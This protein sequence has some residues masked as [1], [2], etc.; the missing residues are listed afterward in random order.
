[1]PAAPS[2]GIHCGVCRGKGLAGQRPTY[3]AQVRCRHPGEG[4]H[5]VCAH[6]GVWGSSSVWLSLRPGAASGSSAG[7]PQADH[8]SQSHSRGHASP[9]QR[10]PHWQTLCP[11]PGLCDGKCSL[12]NVPGHKV[13]SPL[14]S[15]VGKV[16]ARISLAMYSF[17][18]S[19]PHGR[20][21]PAWTLGLV[22]LWWKR[23]GGFEVTVWY[24]KNIPVGHFPS[25]PS[26]SAFRNDPGKGSFLH[27]CPLRLRPVL[28][29]PV[30]AGAAPRGTLLLGE[31]GSTLARGVLLA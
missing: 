28:G 12:G 15:P 30:G 4:A 17:S 11:L 31:R 2:A 13:R 19:L 21:A 5:S 1:M 25:G 23:T 26:S 8:R 29:G 16:Q 10:Q 6:G 27:F 22:W 9:C 14:L 20:L 3:R 24:L 18:W 7:R